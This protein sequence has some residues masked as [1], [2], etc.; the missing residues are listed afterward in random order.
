MEDPHKAHQW[1][2]QVWTAIE[3][4]NAIP[5]MTPEQVQMAMTWPGMLK[6]EYRGD[7]WTFADGK[8]SSTI[9]FA[10]G[11]VKAVA[12]RVKKEGAEDED[13]KD[14]SVR[15]SRA[16]HW[17]KPVGIHFFSKDFEEGK[18]LDGDAGNRITFTMT[19]INNS[20]RD[21]RAV[22]GTLVF[23]DLFDKPIL[24][25]GVTYEEFIQA[26]K[27]SEPYKGGLLYNQFKDEH[28]RLKSV[29][30]G[31]LITRWVCKEVVYSDGTKETVTK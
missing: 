5:G 29:D 6:A 23:S 8:S 2:Q 28:R 31:N 18:I 10:N 27:M 25:V 1:P 14:L 3:Q 9:T 22:R 12:T 16:A 15:V 19:F 26:G 24:S 11:A 4:G 30:Q 13:E 20:D 7:V 17:T 21:V